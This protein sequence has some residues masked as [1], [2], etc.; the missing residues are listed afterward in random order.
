M[1]ERHRGRTVACVRPRGKMYT[2]GGTSSQA[3]VSN[4]NT[5]LWEASEE[6]SREMG[7]GKEIFVSN[8]NSTRSKDRAICI[9]D[10]M[11]MGT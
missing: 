9:R 4:S 3:W 5:T 2:D 8:S 6:R 11:G 10:Q 1:Y 7:D